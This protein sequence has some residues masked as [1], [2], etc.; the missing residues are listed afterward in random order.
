MPSGFFAPQKVALEAW[1]LVFLA[2][3]ALAPKNAPRI[4]VAAALKVGAWV[5]GETGLK[6]WLK[7]GRAWVGWGPIAVDVGPWVARP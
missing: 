7:G 2:K 6:R 5:V 1:A 3:W 4:G